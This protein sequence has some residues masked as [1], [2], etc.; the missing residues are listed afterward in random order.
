VDTPPDALH[1]L[2][3]L[4]VGGGIEATE[5]LLNHAR[6]WQERF[7]A[8]PRLLPISG[9][10]SS[11]DL[12]RYA[13]IG[14]I[15][16]GEERLRDYTA[17]WGEQILSALDTATQTAR[18]VTDSWLMGPLRGPFRSLSRQMQSELTRLIRRGRVEEAVSR[19]MAT[20]VGDEL[21]SVILGYLSSKP[22]VRRLIE[23][24]GT[25][26]AGEMLDEVRNQSS[27][28]DSTLEAYVRRL[29]NQAP[30]QPSPPSST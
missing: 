22:E 3:C 20:E 9:E 12:L 17:Q 28:A 21:V 7:A 5:L 27:A 8:T 10:Q 2:T 6:T 24:Q 14:L 1:L 4:L 26:L 18:P 13:L 30:R 23:E 25:S 19:M 11:T 29:F 16:D 15:F